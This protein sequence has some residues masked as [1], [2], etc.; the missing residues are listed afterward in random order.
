LYGNTVMIHVGEPGIR[1]PTPVIDPAV[2]R[3]TEHQVRVGLACPVESGPEVVRVSPPH[4][5]Q[6]LVDGVGMGI[7]EA[8]AGESLSVDGPG[9]GQLV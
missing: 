7:D 4:I 8:S 1:R 3:S 9:S 2:P 6:I 5:R